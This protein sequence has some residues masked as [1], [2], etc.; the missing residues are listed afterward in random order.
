MRS[1]IVKLIPALVI[2]MLM[3]VSC[4]KDETEERIIEYGVMSDVE[5]HAYTTVKIGD[6]WWMA[7]NLRVGSFN[8]GAPIAYIPRIDGADTAWANCITPAYMS[9]N[10]SVFGKLYNGAVIGS[11]KSIAPVGWHVPTDEDW[12]K[13]EQALGMSVSES[14]QT[15]WRGDNEADLMTSKYNLG[16]PAGDKEKGLYGLD[17]YGFDALPS[18]CRGADGRTNIQNNTAFWW[19]SSR[20]GN[21]FIYRYIDLMKKRVFRQQIPA[22]YGMCIRCVKN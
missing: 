5:G 13:L 17:T 6:Q 9:I 16:W 18:G 14:N 11:E 20:I 19:S 2:P 1:L 21:D 7:E 4:K 15:G 22:G 12:K 10:D 8:D 3:L